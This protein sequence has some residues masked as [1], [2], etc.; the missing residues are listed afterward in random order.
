MHMGII[1][2]TINMC[3]C[4]LCK[5]AKFMHPWQILL[6]AICLLPCKAIY[7]IYIHTNMH[8]LVFILK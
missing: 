1:N 4:F 5:T 3:E 6:K 7:N 2:C 8:I